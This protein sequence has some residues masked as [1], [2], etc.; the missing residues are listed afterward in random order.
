MESNYQLIENERRF[1][2]L[3]ENTP[4][5][6]LFQDQAGVILDVNRTFLDLV[7]KQKDEVIGQLF[8]DFLPPALV[9]LFNQKLAEAFMGHKV[10]FDAEVLFRGATEAKVL[11]VTKVPVLVDG[12]ITGVHMV[13]RDITEITASHHTIEQQARKLNTIFESIT[14]AFFLLDR[15][16][17][18]VIINREVERL[19]EVRREQVIGRNMWDVFPEPP[20]GVF[21]RHYQHAVA[22]GRAVHF[23]AR[24]EP[25]QLWLE[26]RAF[27]SEEG[28][29]V[30][31]SNITDK[32]KAQEELYRQNRDLQQFTYIVSHNLR[33]PLANV[34]GL[35]DLL[36]TTDKTSPDYEETL[37]HLQR[38]AHQLD[39]VLQ[40][41]NTILSIREGQETVPSEQVSLADVAHQAYVNLQEPLEQSGSTVE[42]HIPP[43]LSLAANRAYL[44]SI[45]FNL[46][47]NS[48][49]YRAEERPLQVVVSA[50]RT[51][52]GSLRI[53]F[54]DNG[55]GFDLE[56]AGNDVFKLY[57]RFHTAQQGRGMGLFLVKTHVEAMGG[58]IEVRSTV[59]VGTEFLIY[60]R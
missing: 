7:H 31:F 18:F 28:L 1:R 27:P 40:D 23:E 26:V 3:F 58:T 45:F 22:T 32:V 49:K 54:A 20:E 2:A 43:A 41:M 12:V 14:D 47:S 5:I 11:N 53:S 17:R 29:S 9:P 25:Q 55:T 33:A 59:G 13:S 56:K 51:P 15:D 16:W 8:A 35:V 30:Y 24:F 19:L 46:L 37:D 50:G 34:L 57:K 39:A 21:H 60:L 6:M 42:L 48:L 4:D 10:R 38:N 44:Y 36:D 52:E